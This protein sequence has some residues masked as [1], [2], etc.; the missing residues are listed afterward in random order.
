MN[1]PPI[2]LL[3][4]YGRETPCRLLAQHPFGTVDVE[5]IA[6]GQCFRASGFPTVRE[7]ELREGTYVPTGRTLAYR[8]RDG[9]PVRMAQGGAS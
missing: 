5:R 1:T 4:V 8:W 9:S 3:S 6:D 7:A 2:V